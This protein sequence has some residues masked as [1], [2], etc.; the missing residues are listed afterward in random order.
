MQAGISKQKIDIPESFYPSEGYYGALDNLYVRTLYLKT[1][2]EFLLISFELTSIQ[3]YEIKNL[4]KMIHDYSHI[5]ERNIWITVTHTFSTPH[6]R[7]MEAIQ[8]KIICKQNQIFVEALETACLQACK[9]AL[10]N[11]VP[12]KVYV[13]SGESDINVNRDIETESGWWIG[14]NENRYS[15]NKIQGIKLVDAQ[16]K[17]MATLFNYDI[18][19]SILENAAED[20]KRYVS[21]DL[22]GFT[23]RKIEEY[24]GIAIFLI[25]GAADQ[26]PKESADSYS[27]GKS[28]IEYLGIKLAQDIQ[29]ADK[30]EIHI[31]TIECKE[32]TIT[33][34]GQKKQ[35]FHLLSPTRSYQFEKDIP[36]ETTIQYLRFDDVVWIGLKPE[37]SSQMAEQLRTTSPFPYTFVVTMVNGGDKY[38][39]LEEAYDCVMYEAMNSPFYKGSGEKV[40]KIIIHTLQ[41][42][43]GVIEDEIR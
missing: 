21:S 31:N 15:S 9:C 36:H 7:S 11:Y 6:V 17:V 25:G 22:L 30:R 8:D 34:I 29:H 35:D 19:S 14:K 5:P 24:G 1:E 40:M 23:C 37:I 39:P 2:T 3:E 4:K 33:C 41:E 12:V 18:R 13:L 26:T 16:E 28:M 32:Q 27:Q 43:K 38:M 10:E 42:M 20:G